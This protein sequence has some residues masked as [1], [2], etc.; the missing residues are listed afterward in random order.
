MVYAWWRDNPHNRA[1]AMAT[2]TH[3]LQMGVRTHGLG[4][5]DNTRRHS[6]G[7]DWPVKD[8]EDLNK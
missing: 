8:V 6:S 7:R 2:N 1:L 4:M 3:G 5:F